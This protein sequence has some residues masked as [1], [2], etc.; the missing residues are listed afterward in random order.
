MIDIYL[1]YRDSTSW[2]LDV[3]CTSHITSKQ[4]LR[5]SEVELRMENGAR[6]VVVLRVVNLMLPSKYCLSSQEFYSILA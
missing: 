6:V 5:K 4:K 2:V 1:S 3:G